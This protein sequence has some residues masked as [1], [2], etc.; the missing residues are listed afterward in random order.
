VH[1]P[2]PPPSPPSSAL[3][4]STC[5]PAH[6]PARLPAQHAC[7][8]PPAC[9]PPVLRPP[10][11][12]HPLA[13]RPLAARGRPDARSS[14][15]LPLPI[16]RPPLL[17]PARLLLRPFRPRPL[18]AALHRARRCHR[19]T[20]RVRAAPSP[21]RSTR[22]SS[23]S[24]SLHVHRLTARCARIKNK[25]C[26]YIYYNVGIDCHLS[27]GADAVGG[28][29]SVDCAH[30]GRCAQQAMRAACT[31]RVGYASCTTGNARR[32]QGEEVWG[33][34]VRDVDEARRGRHA[35]GANGTLSRPRV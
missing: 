32:V 33:V 2:T 35:T 21:A 14:R 11:A 15:L 6:R 18:A 10:L 29:R 19:F 7:C 34:W 28:A 17:P 3:M 24:E 8:P 26:V 31:A 13:R 16:V 23:A 20:P 9:S 1:H 22:R 5:P 30:S 25:T 4:L 12:R 27:S